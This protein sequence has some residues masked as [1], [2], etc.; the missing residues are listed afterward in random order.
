MNM[1]SLMSRYDVPGTRAV[2]LF[3]G[4]PAMRDQVVR[5]LGPRLHMTVVG[6]LS[7]Q[8]GLATLE[9]LR[10]RVGA[11]V[12]GGRYDAAQRQRIRDYV[13]RTLPGVTVAEPG[14]Q[15]PYDHELLL[16]RLTAALGV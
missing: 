5:F 13:T 12:I 14:V 3:G 2:V 9:A 11:V 4:N 8:E 1:D 7:E 15:F 16:G 10:D 6:T